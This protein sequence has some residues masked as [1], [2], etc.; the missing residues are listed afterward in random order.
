[1]SHLFSPLPFL[2]RHAGGPQ[3]LYLPDHA[4]EVLHEHQKLPFE[5]HVLPERGC[6]EAVAHRGRGLLPELAP[7]L[8]ARP[9]RELVTIVERAWIHQNVLDLS[10]VHLHEVAVLFHAEQEGT[11]VILPVRLELGIL[12]ARTTKGI[13]PAILHR[14]FYRHRSFFPRDIC[15][16]RCPLPG[17]DKQTNPRVAPFVVSDVQFRRREKP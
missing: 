2:D 7:G 5:A 3:K 14:C 6:E 10:S 12:V 13:Y 9:N 15:Y 4:P 11:R 1:M 17:G 8:R 16:T